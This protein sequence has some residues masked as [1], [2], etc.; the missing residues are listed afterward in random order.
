MK[1]IFTL[2][3]ISLSLLANQFIEVSAT[4][5]KDL[6]IKLQKTINIDVIELGPYNAKATLDQKDVI[7][8]GS[9]LDVVVKDI[10][11][12]KLQHVNKG[13]KLISISS[14][15]LLSLQEKY[16][17]VLIQSKNIDKNYER[18][19]KLNEQG[20]VSDKKYLDSLQEK[21]SSDLMLKL[22][23]NELLSSGFSHNMLSK[24]QSTYQPIMQIDIYAPRSGVI[25]SVDVNIGQKVQSNSSMMMIYADGDRF[26]EFS[27]PVRVVK[28]ISISDKCIFDSFEAKIVSIGNI[29]NEN[30]QTVD[31]RA[32]VENSK[33]IMI[34]RIYSAKIK[35]SVSGIL[36][37]KKS[38]LVYSKNKPY[39]FKKVDGGFEVIGVEIIKEG[40][41]CYVV[42]SKLKEGDS[43][44]VSSTAALLS[45]MEDSDE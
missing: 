30:S 8:I 11:V 14:N 42:D 18:S 38:A 3:S 1:K 16:I 12:R 13:Q 33:D 29:V 39:V 36:K 41:V 20:V 9:N 34:N 44:A 26:V 5:Q 6:G 35:K 31:V 40:P 43:L 10:H 22:S 4:Q 25:H 27:V 37:V 28:N 24:I 21:Q 32:V 2:L 45:A 19:K 7:S 17:K 15:E 23:A